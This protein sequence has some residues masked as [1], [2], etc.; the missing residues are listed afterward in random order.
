M[1]SR[2]HSGGSGDCGD[3]G[4]DFA[5]G[6][7]NAWCTFAALTANPIAAAACAQRC[8]AGDALAPGGKERINREHGGQGARREEEVK[9]TQRTRRSKWRGRKAGGQLES[10]RLG[11]ERLLEKRGAACCAP[12]EKLLEFFGDRK[13]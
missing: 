11:S 13:S 10:A 3:S 1:Y 2:R 9:E 12:T 8:R 5:P 6:G 4:A 7:R